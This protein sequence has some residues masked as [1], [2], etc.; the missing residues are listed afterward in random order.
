MEALINDE[1]IGNHDILLV[2]VHAAYIESVWPLKLEN[3]AEQRWYASMMPVQI[4]TRLSIANDS[5]AA[6]WRAKGC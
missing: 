6:T 1:E 3:V 5:V 2:Q 4:R